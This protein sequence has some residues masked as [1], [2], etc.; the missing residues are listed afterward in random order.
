MASQILQPQAA[1]EEAVLGNIRDS[2]PTSGFSYDRVN[3]GRMYDGQPPP[4]CGNIFLSVWY[5]GQRG[6]LGQ[7]THLSELFG[8][9]LT[10]T[11]R[12]V[13]PFDRWVH[14][15]DDM[16]ARANAIKALICQDTWNYSIIID[17]NK[18]AGFRTSSQPD[19]VSPVGWCEPLVF[20][21]FD[22]IQDVG[23]DWFHADPGRVSE[24]DVGIA[25]R[26]K[27]GM[28]KRIQSLATA[29]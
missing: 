4:R 23:A 6:T 21:G 8:V 9:Y 14:H 25:Q 12:F 17:A 11:L 18:R 22:P 2:A 20:Q 19:N 27:F 24:R 5:D 28:A 1:L 16:E 15:R 3:S 13:Q 10:L 26:I 7:R 29:T